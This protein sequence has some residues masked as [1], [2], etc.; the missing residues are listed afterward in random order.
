MRNQTF[1]NRLRDL[2]W[3]FVQAVFEGK[4]FGKQR[5]DSPG[6]FQLDDSPLS[7][8]KTATNGRVV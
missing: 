3:I 6:V 2:N 8:V 1:E 4:Y 7:S 5:L